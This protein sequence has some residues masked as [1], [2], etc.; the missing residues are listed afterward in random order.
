MIKTL[1][2]S[3]AVLSTN[4]PRTQQALTSVTTA[5]GKQTIVI[6]APRSGVTTVGQPARI[7]TTVPKA[8]GAITGK[9]LRTLLLYCHF[10]HLALTNMV[11]FKDR[12][13]IDLYL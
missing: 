3:G 1:T 5:G 9:Q 7:V 12:Y 6:A 8:G 11:G 2:A 13:F 10:T 4:T